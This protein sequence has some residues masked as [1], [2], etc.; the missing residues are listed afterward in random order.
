MAKNKKRGNADHF[1]GA[2]AAA[3]QTKK[4]TNPFEVHVNKEKFSI[5]GRQLKHD[6]GMPGVSRGKALKRRKDTLG[7]EF[8]N[9]NKTNK[10]VDKRIGRF[11]MTREES[12]NARFMAEQLNKFKKQTKQSKYN[13]SDETV[14]THK[15]QT[16]LEIEQFKD[17]VSEEEDIDDE[18]LGKLDEKFT[19]TAHFGGDPDEENDTG[20]GRSRKD[21]IEDLIAEQKRRKI[22]ISKEKE[23]VQQM[24]DLLD[25]NWRSLIPLMGKLGKVDEVKPK[26]DDY[27]R[28]MREMIFEPR[29]SVSDK[30]VSEQEILKKE[31]ERLEKLEFERQQRMEGITAEDKKMTHRSADDLDD[32]YFLQPVVDQK[33][34]D[35]K[36]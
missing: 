14:L 20:G 22:E 8:A 10:F 33:G 1:S 15:G 23:E 18:E 16:L 36:M 4:R 30:L 12:A 26:P 3:S 31:K 28:A 34:N 29:G 32:G 35:G 25:A 24:T 6:K 5:L 11:S 19:S 2:R 27:D 21:A 7:K 13:L 17:A 9:K